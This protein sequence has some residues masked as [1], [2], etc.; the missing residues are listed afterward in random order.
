MYDS[1]P[2]YEKNVHCHDRFL[3]D[4]LSENYEALFVLHS[5]NHNMIRLTFLRSKKNSIQR[6]LLG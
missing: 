4:F 6:L 3:Y 2:G 5:K 1:V